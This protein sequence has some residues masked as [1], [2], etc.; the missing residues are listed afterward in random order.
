MTLDFVGESLTTNGF[1]A[2][3]FGG[4]S[5]SN[6]SLVPTNIKEVNIVGECNIAERAFYYCRTISTISLSDKVT[7]I[8]QAAFYY[9][10][11]LTT[12]NIPA[13]VTTL[14]NEV[15]S[16]T[17]LR[18]IF[19][20]S[21]ITSIS[22]TA[23]YYTSNLTKITVDESNPIYD[24]RNNC[25]AIVETSTN[26]IIKGSKKTVYDETIVAIGDYAFS[27][28]YSD[29]YTI[30][31]VP[32]TI[33]EIGTSAFAGANQISSLTVP[34]IGKNASGETDLTYILGQKPTLLQ[35]VTITG[36]CVI[37]EKAFYQYAKLKT[38]NIQGVVTQIGNYAFYGCTVLQTINLPSGLESIGS[39]A[40]EYCTNLQ[41]IELPNTVTSLGIY[42]FSECEA[43]KTIT[44][45]TGLTSISKYTFYKCASL[46][47]I[48][49]PNNITIIDEYA[50]SN[51]KKLATI[52][53]PSELLSIEKCA[54]ENCIALTTITLPSKLTTIGSQ[55]FSSC[56]NLT[57]VFIPKSVENIIGFA[58]SGCT[59][60]V[61]YCEIAEAN[62][63]TGWKKYWNSSVKEIKYNCTS[64]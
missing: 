48:I 12:F 26:K 33:Q 43:L 31:T 52:T 53:L 41:K 29:A 24:S 30:I 11:S 3:I 18:E 58:F 54:F 39:R 46:T 36:N 44:L 50:F 4:T 55:A 2:Y 42:A 13:G 35:Q 49:L 27:G 10:T 40:F 22:S 20:P 62:I 64:I 17:G 15:F 16:N 37:P 60:L 61:L 14:N 8:G 47:S 57:K 45:S 5:Y 32:N 34:F 51:C 6:Y 38:V 28:C 19:I 9:C 23:F 63:P 1:F 25:N 21:Q 56:T 7:S 59:N